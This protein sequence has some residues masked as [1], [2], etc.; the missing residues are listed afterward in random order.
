MKITDR[1]K[2]EYWRRRL[3]ED[4]DIN[5][6][7]A[8]A[9]HYIN[10]VRAAATSCILL[11]QEDFMR[12]NE[13][14]AH[15]VNSR[16]M[17]Q[18]PIYDVR[19]LTDAEGNVQYG[20][21]GKPKTE[22]FVSGF[23]PVE[24]VRFGLQRRINLSKAAH[25]AGNGYWVAHEG[26]EH[27]LAEALNS[28]KDSAGLDNAFMEVI[29]SC[30]LTGD[31][32]VYLY[33]YNNQLRYQVFSYLKGD[34]LFF[35][36]DEEHNP[37]LTRLYTLRGRRA[38]DIYSTSRVQTWIEGDADE[39]RDASWWS[40]FGG[41]FAK[42]LDW[43]S[44]RR[45]EDGWR[46][47]SDRLTQ[48]PAGMNPCVYFRV[49][50]IPSGVADQE[51]A[52]LEKACSFVA[53]GVRSVSQPVLFVKATD[54]ETLPQSDSTGKVIGVKGAVDEISAADAKF[55]TPPNLSDIATIDIGNKKEAILHSTMSVN[56]TPEIFRSTD[57]SSSA[58][59]LL[60]SDTLIW[61]KNEFT[62][63]YPSLCDI[64]EVTKALVAKIENNGKI[65]TMRTSCGCDFWIPQNDSEVL[66]RELDMVTYRVKSRKAAMADIGN[67]HLEDYEQI[68][69]EWERELDIKARIPAEAKAQADAKHAETDNTTDTSTDA[70]Q[71]KT[72]T[73]NAAPGKSIE[74]R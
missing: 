69:R 70:P 58:I 35:D 21:D 19:R 26:R 27:E 56:I 10:P 64:V 61:C 49:H 8:N 20:D 72:D 29:K 34:E 9:G 22:W 43:G 44:T 71:A 14:S 24:T 51:I 25:M 63:I 32:A 50:D 33:I 59:K 60:F 54:I 38:V 30:Y 23:E 11:T 2:K 45:S 37:T 57:P 6:I 31:A 41:W 73:S 17:S 74:Q 4:S 36:Y 28:H 18:R 68:E 1:L 13:P 5:H 42:G 16:Y 67:E 15:E 39:D 40:R 3:A 62:E 7:P 65:A 52:A 53:D 66:K 48:T 47:I 12:E 55:L 46:C